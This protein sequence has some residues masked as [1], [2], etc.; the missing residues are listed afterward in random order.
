[1]TA[2]MAMDPM[3]APVSVATDMEPVSGF[4]DDDESVAG[5]LTDALGGDR[6]DDTTSSEVRIQF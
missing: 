5:N 1:M 3:I 6:L 2:T 4:T